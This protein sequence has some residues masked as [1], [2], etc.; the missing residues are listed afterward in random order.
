MIHIF[1]GPG[2]QSRLKLSE[3]LGVKFLQFAIS[4]FQL[5]CVGAD[6]RSLVDLGLHLIAPHRLQ[7]TKTAYTFGTWE[8]MVDPSY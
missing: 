6:E 2:V 4:V 1:G 7:M 5:V 8:P 3:S